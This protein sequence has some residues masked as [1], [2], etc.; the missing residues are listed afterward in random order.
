MKYEAE[1]VY[2]SLGTPLL[3]RCSVLNRNGIFYAALKMR[4]QELPLEVALHG[5]NSEVE[6][7][8][9]LATLSLL[10]GTEC[11]LLQS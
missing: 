1:K 3:D 5:I 6:A 2:S 9:A 11:S 7:R 10:R 8:Q 4:G